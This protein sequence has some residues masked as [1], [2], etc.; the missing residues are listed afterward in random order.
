MIFSPQVFAIR[1]GQSGGRPAATG[2]TCTRYAV[3]QQVAVGSRHTDDTR[4][5]R[6]LGVYRRAG[7]PCR[8]RSSTIDAQHSGASVGFWLFAVSALNW[9]SRKIF[10]F[11]RAPHRVLGNYSDQPALKYS[12]QPALEADMAD[13]K[14]GR[15][16][17][18]QCLLAL[19][20]ASIAALAAGGV[21]TAVSLVPTVAAT[22]TAAN[23]LVASFVPDAPPPGPPQPPEPPVPPGAPGKVDA[24]GVMGPH[25]LIGPPGEPN[26]LILPGEIPGPNF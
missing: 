23:T 8:R 20:G 6:Q 24:P 15:K 12:D 21:V 4:P 13:G 18:G 25:G 10:G 2:V 7:L 26:P 19:L 16:H 1:I 22:P 3:G 17:N 14:T 11:H 5:G 9:V